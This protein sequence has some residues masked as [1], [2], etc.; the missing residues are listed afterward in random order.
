MHLNRFSVKHAQCEAWK[1]HWVVVTFAR[2]QGFTKHPFI[3]ERHFYSDQIWPIGELDW[4]W[5]RGDTSEAWLHHSLVTRTLKRQ[6][7]KS[8]R[9]VT[10]WSRLNFLWIILSQFQISECLTFGSPWAPTRSLTRVSWGRGWPRPS[11]RSPRSI[12]LRGQSA[13]H[14]AICQESLSL[15]IFVTWFSG[16]SKFIIC[17][18]FSALN[19][20]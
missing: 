6:L 1:V 13:G 18:L 20:P 8:H 9:C 17:K 3:A 11:T 5:V 10:S 12:T 15:G 7:L 19:D 4:A 16:L 14:A 2:S